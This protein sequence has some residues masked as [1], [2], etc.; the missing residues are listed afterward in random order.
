MLMRGLIPSAIRKPARLE[1]NVMAGVSVDLFAPTLITIGESLRS[2]GL[3]EDVHV[4]D[5]ESLRAALARIERRA[6]ERTREQAD[7]SSTSS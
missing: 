4:D 6:V 1:L 5:L 7:E 3:P 2:R